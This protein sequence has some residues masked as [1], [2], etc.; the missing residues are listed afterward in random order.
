V[1]DAINLLVEQANAAVEI[2]EEIVEFG[3]RI[4]S[5]SCQLVVLTGQDLG[6]RTP[7]PGNALG[8]SESAIE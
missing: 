3:D 1:K 2:A 8:N 7:R 5:H 4:A 6:N